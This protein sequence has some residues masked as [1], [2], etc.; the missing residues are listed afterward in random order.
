[1]KKII[2]AALASAAFVAM[3]AHAAPLLTYDFSGLT[4]TTT[5]VAAGGEA[6]NIDGLNLTRG[7]GLTAV[8]ATRGF[9]SSGWNNQAS[10]YLTFGFNIAAGY[11][12]TVSDIVFGAE[13]SGSG[14]STISLSAST[15][16]GSTFQSLTSFAQT[17]Q[18]RVQNLT[19][20]SLTS[21]SSII[22]RLTGTGATA[23]GGTFRLTNANGN[24]LSINGSVSA[25]SAV[26]EP[27]A[28]ALMILGFGV[29]GASMRRRQ[30]VRVTF[31]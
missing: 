6:A 29:V 9:N 5:S 2:A 3:P 20:G 30:S 13:R 23:P 12:A 24:P 22:F 1:M 31:A 8:S 14:P 4:S 19:F 21:A 15:D 11:T 18:N 17:T 10:D 27:A 16:G 7:S 28:W 26:P 25:I